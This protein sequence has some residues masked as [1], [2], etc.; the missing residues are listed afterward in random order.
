MAS[1]TRSMRMKREPLTSTD[2]GGRACSSTASIS[3][4]MVSKWRA[5]GER[6]AA[7]AA[8]SGPVREQVLDAQAL[9][10]VTGLGMEHLALVADLAHV[11]QHH[12][13]RR[14][15]RGEQVRARH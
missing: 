5:A 14:R 10:L 12:Q 15:H 7:A 11:A 13:A 9:G 3:A 1:T 4:G 8:D 6:F 2:A